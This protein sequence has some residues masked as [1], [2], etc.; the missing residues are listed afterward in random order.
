MAT[1]AVDPGD[2]T[3][4]AIPPLWQRPLSIPAM[5]PPKPSQTGIIG[6]QWGYGF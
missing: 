1:A 5:P 3:A 4:E 6:W 2:A